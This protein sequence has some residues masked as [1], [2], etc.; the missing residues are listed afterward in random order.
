LGVGCGGEEVVFRGGVVV[1]CGQL[2]Q[3]PVRPAAG[4]M[5]GLSGCCA[6][7]WSRCG[8]VGTLGFI[9]AEGYPGKALDLRARRSAFCPRVVSRA[10]KRPSMPMGYRGVAGPAERDGPCVGRAQLRPSMS[11]TCGVRL[12]RLVLTSEAARRKLQTR[13]ASV[14][15]G[16]TGKRRCEG[17][18]R[19]RSHRIFGDLEDGLALP[20]L[21][22]E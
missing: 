4:D 10:V 15:L 2:G 12:M 8:C 6:Q 14:R 13:G 11:S 19:G 9:V 17:M 21:M 7:A 18:R 20:A 5:G 16:N 1:G 3:G 22:K